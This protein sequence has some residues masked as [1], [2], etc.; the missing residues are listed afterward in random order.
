M[1]SENRNPKPAQQGGWFGD[2]F[3][4][5]GFA[6]RASGFTGKLDSGERASSWARLVA[7]S[8]PSSC[9]PQH[10][11]RAGESPVVFREGAENGARGGRAPQSTWGFGL[12][13]H[14]SFVIRHSAAVAFVLALI[15]AAAAAADWP[16][17]M[18]DAQRSGISAEQLA[19]NL[20]PAWVFPRIAKPRAAWSSEAKSDYWNGIGNTLKNRLDFDAVNQVAVAGGRVYVGSSTEDT[21]ICL[22]AATGEPQWKFFADGPVRM[23]PAVSGGRVCFGSDDGSAYCLNA[24]DGTQFWKYTPAGTNNYLVPNNGAFVSPWAVRSGVVVDSG[25]AY[26]AAGIFPGVGVHVCALNATTGARVWQ[27]SQT[28]AG[29][30]QG[31]ALI[32]SSR[33]FVPGSRSNPYFC[34]RSDGSGWTQYNGANAFGTFALLAGTNLFM[35]PANGG[36][37]NGGGTRITAANDSGGAVL[38]T[39]A[40]NAMV[41]TAT[42]TYLLSDTALQRLNRA[43]Q[44]VT[45]SRSASYPYALILA[46]STLYAGGDNQVAAF[47][48]VTG[49]PLWTAA[50]RGRAGGLAVANGLLFV[51]TD[52]GVVEAF[53]SQGKPQSLLIIR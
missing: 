53:A 13:R 24:V 1:K 9:A 16:T 33:L 19:T 42:D 35:G 46:G 31:Y 30:L 6:L 32:S 47:D 44:T 23:A 50:V 52:Q 34:N 39:Y 17:Y 48:T 4:E 11:A 20:V 14:S 8:R 45:W 29:A 51:S 3:D 12:L 15:S 5:L 27:R 26:C 40:G 43:T 21:V 10:G 18:A 22:N 7:P 37:G 36:G 2:W 25:T 38:A 28:N 49:N 41:V